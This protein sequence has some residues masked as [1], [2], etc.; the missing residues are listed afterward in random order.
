MTE[1][2]NEVKLSFSLSG[3]IYTHLVKLK[4]HIKSNI[5][6]LYF[7]QLKFLDKQ[8]LIKEMIYC[9]NNCTNDNKMNAAVAQMF[10]RI[11]SNNHF[12][13]EWF[14]NVMLILLLT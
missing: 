7:T 11:T 3:T 14:A 9:K 12:Q 5:L 4:Q 2:L 1:L 13:F 8:P 6:P 10:T